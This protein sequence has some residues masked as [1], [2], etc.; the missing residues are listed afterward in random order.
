M[1][2]VYFNLWVAFLF[3]VAYFLRC[4]LIIV[5]IRMHV[6]TKNLKKIEL[7]ILNNKNITLH[8]GKNTL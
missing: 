3:Y 6:N 8:T 2:L 1:Q 5:N 4:F 7:H